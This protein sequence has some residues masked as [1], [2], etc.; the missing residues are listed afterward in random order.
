M[1]LSHRMN[2]FEFQSVE[3]IDV[4]EEGF[5]WMGCRYDSSM[6]SSWL[7]RQTDFEAL[8]SVGGEFDRTASR[9]IE[10]FEFPNLTYENRLSESTIGFGSDGMSVTSRSSFV[11]L[12]VNE[13]YTAMDVE[14]SSFSEGDHS[15][16]SDSV[17]HGSDSLCQVEVPVYE[18]SSKLRLTT[19]DL[20]SGSTLQLTET[21]DVMASSS[22][23][24]ALQSQATEM[25]CESAAIGLTESIQMTHFEVNIG[26]LVMTATKSEAVTQ[27]N[28]M[29]FFQAS[30]LASVSLEMP[31][32]SIFPASGFSGSQ[33]LNSQ[34]TAMSLGLGDL[35]FGFQSTEVS[36]AGIGG[37]FGGLFSNFISQ[38]GD[39]SLA[40]G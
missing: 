17:I 27:M 6:A 2:E 29:S 11:T 10:T 22:G 13:F 18:F 1:F 31:V 20:G 40:I 28:G 9:A 15:M 33:R 35:Q 16:T 32:D 12:D 30:S 4:E 8:G 25:S 7:L 36:S 34:S 14:L 38:S 3:S 24:F 19:M 39:V 5:D 23:G 37:R 26:N 21:Q